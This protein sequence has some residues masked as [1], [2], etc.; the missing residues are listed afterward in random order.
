MRPRPSPQSLFTRDLCNPFQRPWPLPS[1]SIRPFKTSP[2]VVDQPLYP[3]PD[4]L[5]ARPRFGSIP[6]RTINLI[7]DPK[8]SPLITS[9]WCFVLV[10]RWQGTRLFPFICA[11]PEL[12]VRPPTH[13]E[14]FPPLLVPDVSSA[15]LCLWPFPAPALLSR[16]ARP[17]S[18]ARQSRCVP[19]NF[20]NRPTTLCRLPH[21]GS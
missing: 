5:L 3:Y 14:R 18:S 1:T 17:A 10:A 8:R 12:L 15:L 4:R 21:L 11:P 9:I 20:C 2:G 7:T 13:F 6:A 19:F 16:S